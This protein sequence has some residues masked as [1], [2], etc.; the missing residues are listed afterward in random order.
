MLGSVWK[1]HSPKSKFYKI[2]VCRV[3]WEEVE[4]LGQ[5]QQTGSSGR[6]LNLSGSTLFNHQWPG[7]SGLRTR[8]MESPTFLAHLPQA[9]Q[10]KWLLER[11]PSLANGRQRS[12]ADVVNP[13]PEE[14]GE[15]MGYSLPLS[16]LS[17]PG[18]ITGDVIGSS[19]FCN[20]TQGG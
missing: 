15:W 20:R 17:G 14:T 8:I 11:N 10:K 4:H 12:A 5:N 7:L 18:E 3:S 2:I 6:D 13:L 19:I 1:S 9:A 16:F